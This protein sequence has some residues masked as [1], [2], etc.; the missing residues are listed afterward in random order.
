MANSVK[1]FLDASGVSILWSRF[2]DAL[3]TE[4]SRAKA[5]EKL[6][7]EAAE[8]A[9]GDVDDLK[10]LVGT[11]PEGYESQSTV[12]SYI[13]K[14]AEETLA[15]AQGGST[16]TAASVKT[17]LDNYKKD[18]DAAVGANTAAIADIKKD[19]LTSADKT[20]LNTAIGA[21][22]TEIARVNAVLVAALENEDTSALDSIKEL[23][24]WIENHDDAAAGYAQDI[25]A[26]Q[27]KVNTG[28]QTVTAYVASQLENYA[29]DGELEAL[30][31][32]VETLEN[33]GY[34]NAEQVSSAI[35]SGISHLETKTDA[36]AK[37]NTAK[38]Y[39]DTEFAKIQSLSEAEIDAAIAAAE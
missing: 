20:E 28:E 37:L 23:A 36:S 15:A 13:D 39:T 29:T 31:G 10:E 21:N 4:S 11:I 26:L 3:D 14:K 34:Q 19:Y 7:K 32:R 1:K 24:T 22:T 16:E 38:G 12:V 18:N 27:N 2:M 5:A 9:Q 35:T 17:Q 25:T 8:K 33:A 6:N 30:D